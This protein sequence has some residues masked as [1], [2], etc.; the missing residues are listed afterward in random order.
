MVIDFVSVDHSWL[1]SP[2]GR[3]SAC[4]LFHAGKNHEGYFD[5]QNICDQAA[6]AMKSL[7]K[8]YPDKDHVFIFDNTT[9]HLKF[10]EGALSALKMTKGPSANFMVKVN[11][12]DNKGS[13]ST[14]P[15]KIFSKR[16]CA[17]QM[18]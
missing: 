11:D 10:P 12:L 15:I 8:H 4:V 5:N 18:K 6:K 2:D 16:K 13:H 9:T 3:E 7:Q 14:H 1:Q 17:Q